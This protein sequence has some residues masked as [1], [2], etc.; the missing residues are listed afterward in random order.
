MSVWH[1]LINNTATTAGQLKIS[2]IW[3]VPLENTE[4]RW[5]RLCE[6][7]VVTTDNH[8]W[9][10]P[11]QGGSYQT[12]V[13]C[14]NA[15]IFVDK[16]SYNFAKHIDSVVVLLIKNLKTSVLW[17]VS[18]HTGLVNLSFYQDQ[19]TSGIGCCLLTR[20]QC[21]E[22]FQLYTLLCFLSIK[23]EIKWVSHD[24]WTADVLVL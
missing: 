22:S 1:H 13:R 18:V 14:F 15:E 7:D 9:I 4:W 12:I 21:V 17:K 6:D 23:D 3:L 11:I 16:K 20:V 8:S 19:V 5:L 2:L 24:V 10:N